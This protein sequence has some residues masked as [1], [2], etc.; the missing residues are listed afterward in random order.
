MPDSM[1]LEVLKAGLEDKW[2]LV[3]KAAAQ[4]LGKAGDPQ[5]AEALKK[6]IAVEKDSEV[7][8]AM[9]AALNKV[10]EGRL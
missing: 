7:K 10:A 2:E 4:S 3:R 9:E 6:A 5:A 1:A 8:A